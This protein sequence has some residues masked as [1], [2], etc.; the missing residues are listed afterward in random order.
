MTPELS[1]SEGYQAR[2]PGF[3]AERF[4]NYFLF[5]NRVST[6]HSPVAILD[7]QAY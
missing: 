6:L 5:V 7:P 4:F 2:A 3:L 1:L